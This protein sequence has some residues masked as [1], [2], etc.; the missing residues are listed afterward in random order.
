MQVEDNMTRLKSLEDG[1]G[2]IEERL[3]KV[4]DRLTGIETAQVDTN[5]SLN[6]L[7]AG[8][9]QTNTRLQSLE[10]GQ[11]EILEAIQNL[12]PR[13]SS[14][15][16][17]AR[18]IVDE[19]TRSPS[20]PQGSQPSQSPSLLRRATGRLSRGQRDRQRRGGRS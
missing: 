7:E 17:I 16:G 3:D 2:R 14:K 5:K 11:R 13:P 12:N 6:N 1:Q 9:G 15:P 4:D 8:Q 18:V 20:N 10:S 19:T